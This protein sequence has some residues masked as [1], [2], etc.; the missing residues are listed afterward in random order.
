MKKKNVMII[1]AAVLVCA[2]TITGIARAVRGGGSAVDVTQVS[3]LNS[4]WWDEGTSTSGY[5]TANA[6]Q[7]VYLESDSVVE[8]VY[9]KK[10]DKV[11]IGDTLLEY[12]KTLLQLNLEEE[13]IDKQIKELELQGAKNDL[14]KL[15]KITP[16]ADSEGGSSSHATLFDDPDD[17]SDDSSDGAG[18]DD[19]EA[20]AAIVKHNVSLVS[21]AA[22][23][24]VQVI[25]GNSDGSDSTGTA[26]GETTQQ[27]ES[28]T[29]ESTTP[30]TEPAYP[31]ETESEPETETE[32]ETED[33]P[34]AKTKAYQ[35]LDYKTKYYKGSGT[36]KDPYVYL[37]KEGA[38]VSA[39]FMNKILGFNTDGSSRKEGGV[40]KD[41]KGCYA[42][43]QIREG[44]SLAGGYIKSVTINGTID[45]GKAYAPDVT[46]IFTSQG[47]TKKVPDIQ[48]PQNDNPDEPDDPDDPGDD[49]FEPGDGDYTVS[50]LK[51]AIAEK[52]KEIK[53]LEL[54]IRDAEVSV[55]QAQRK[56]D[57]ATV[58]ATINGVVKTVGDP[59]VGQV[60]GE[61]FLTVTSNKGMYVKGRI[62]EMDLGNVV[63]GST[64]TGTAQESGTPITAEITEISKYPSNSD[65]NYYGGDSNPNASSYPFT[66][67]IE[68]SDD[69]INHEY[70]DI[71]IEGNGGN[72]S[73][74]Y[75]PKALI[76]MENGQSYVY[77]EGKNKKLKKQYVRTGQTLYST[78]IEV[79]EGVSETDWIAFPYGKAVKE[80][81]PVKEL[82]GSGFA[83]QLY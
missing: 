9:V 70:V 19:D 57:E 64:I 53:G 26:G 75:L 69:L 22:G 15:K 8:K 44:D 14:E 76:R 28:Q 63:V 34:L 12:D 50:E 30:S 55:S 39:S 66:A 11:K 78:Y 59:K 7:D 13:Q 46:W 36:K 51:Q 77:I 79:K 4:G 81:A 25:D 71:Q 37:C 27:T 5:V 33:S 17:S 45:A 20:R 10:G 54:D 62:S 38:E 60:D 40:N 61:A 23:A 67:Y 35:K 29:P 21:T 6:S 3:Y 32:E 56:L 52:E 58:K 2:I 1:T 82:E 72:G 18:S 83:D 49:P 65:S 48:D 31:A 68:D 74:V 41:G 80:G 42:V 16:V 24:D 47:I 43:L 73:S